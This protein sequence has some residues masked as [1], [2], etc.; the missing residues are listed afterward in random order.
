MYFPTIFFCT[1]GICKYVNTTF[2]G[3]TNFD[4][5]NVEINFN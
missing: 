1:I 3:D 4:V 5:I 2:V